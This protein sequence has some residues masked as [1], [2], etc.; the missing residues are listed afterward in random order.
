MLDMTLVYAVS[1]LHFVHTRNTYDLCAL[2]KVALPSLKKRKKHCLWT[3]SRQELCLLTKCNWQNKCFLETGLDPPWTS[4]N[5]LHT[6]ECNKNG[7]INHEW[8]LFLFIF[9]LRFIFYQQCSV[10][11]IRIGIMQKSCYNIWTIDSR[12][13]GENFQMHN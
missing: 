10:D 8:L 5:P 4:H 13:E 9:L 1:V 6:Y 3:K 2:Q 11:S 12:Y 7:N